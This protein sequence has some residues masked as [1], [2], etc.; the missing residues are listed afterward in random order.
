MYDAEK[1]INNDLIRVE[2]NLLEEENDYITFDLHVVARYK[3][4]TDGGI[5]EALNKTELSKEEAESAYEI[6]KKNQ[7]PVLCQEVL[8]DV[9]AVYLNGDKNSPISTVPIESKAE[10]DKYLSEKLI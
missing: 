4:I 6:L 5:V 1:S 10:E 9:Q 2:E 8:Y 3:E 7:N